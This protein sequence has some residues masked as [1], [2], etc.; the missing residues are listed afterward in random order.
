MPDN[1]TANDIPVGNEIQMLF[2]PYTS[3]EILDALGN[4]T[5]EFTNELTSSDWARHFKQFI[6]NGVYPNP[7]SGLR[8]DSIHGSMVL[9][10]RMGA[11]FAEGH[12]Y[13]MDEADFE[14]PVPAAHLT[15]GRR[16]I[17]VIRHDINTNAMKPILR[18]G[19]PA[20]TP[21]VPQLQRD[22]DVFELQVAVI[23]VNPAAQ[24]ITQANIL[25]TR[26]DN[27]VCGIV[28]G[29]ID[30]VDT[31]DIFQQYFAIVD[32]LLEF[33]TNERLTWEQKQEAWVKAQETFMRNWEDSA[34][35]W[36]E[37]F[38]TKWQDLI[39][40]LETQALTSI[41]LDF[42]AD[43]TKRGC[44]HKRVLLDDGSRYEA[45]TVRATGMLLA[46]RT[47][48][49]TPEYRTVVTKFFPWEIIITED[50]TVTDISAIKAA[51]EDLQS[52]VVYLES[53]SQALAG[54]V[55]YPS[56]LT[57]LPAQLEK[58]TLYLVGRVAPY[59]LWMLVG[60]T[61][62]Q[63]GETTFDASQIKD[64]IFEGVMQELADPVSAL[65]IRNFW[66]A[67]QRE[68]PTA[69]IDTL[70]EFSGRLLRKQTMRATLEAPAFV[71]AGTET[72]RPP[73][74]LVNGDTNV[75][76][77]NSIVVPVSGVW[78]LSITPPQTPLP[79]TGLVIAS[80][81]VNDK[82]TG[83]SRL[84]LNQGSRI[85]E[86]ISWEGY[87]EAGDTVNLE[88]TG[89]MLTFPAGIQLE[90][91]L[92]SVVSGD[93]ISE[94]G[95]S[96]ISAFGG[97]GI[98][99]LDGSGVTAF[100]DSG[101]SAFASKD[102]VV[103]DFSRCVFKPLKALGDISATISTANPNSFKTIITTNWEQ[104]MITNYATGETEVF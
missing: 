100:S 77:G 68:D 12:T 62:R 78:S 91:S 4:P 33:W 101:V 90:M 81:M 61:P 69:N 102:D 98:A 24:A 18:V 40:A 87:C 80:L 84:I 31:T 63:V 83:R 30:Q 56:V 19:V 53:Y 11:A 51:L 25:D 34:V 35:N 74:S 70:E 55:V 52:R 1:L 89:S 46:E 96:G 76:A 48:V 95:N 5:G 44:T 28:H 39:S 17:V 66:L 8:V 6:G 54:I 10:L 93:G 71:V 3:E 36:L 57:E 58:N 88:V 22:D 82:V 86:T 75:L 38:K 42:D 104:T 72:T 13:V 23:T 49:W 9:T 47:T 32:E 14:I 99:A 7:S 20:L 21:G 92:S 79:G 16:D 85:L 67:W 29:L 37:D 43:W 94:F 27:R 60:D 26:L 73:W 97:V 45:W 41:N 103:S 50:G 15:L 65:Q 64:E 59:T 2:M